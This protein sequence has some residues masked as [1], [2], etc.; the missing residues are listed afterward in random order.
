MK[1]RK[2]L[3]K[4]SLVT[5]YNSFIYP[6]LVYCNHLWGNTYI[7]NLDK[8][9]IMQKEIVRIIAGVRLRTHSGPLFQKYGIM[10]IVEINKYLIWRFMYHVHNS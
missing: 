7:F 1:A 8:L 3:D 2:L 5:L 9:Y 6:Y 10:N 4:E